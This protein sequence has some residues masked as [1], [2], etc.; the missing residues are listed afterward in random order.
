MA[1]RE[2]SFARRERDDARR[3]D[4]TAGG[5]GSSGRCEKT[6]LAPSQLQLTVLFVLHRRGGAGG[7][8]DGVTSMKELL[9]DKIVC[10]LSVIP[11]VDLIQ[12]LQFLLPFS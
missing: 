11:N 12:S 7:D 10:S 6:F 2:L 3:E 9:C 8:R 4:A 5:L 1:A